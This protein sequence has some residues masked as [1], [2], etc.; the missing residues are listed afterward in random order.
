DDGVGG[1][2]HAM[3]VVVVEGMENHERV[4]VGVVPSLVRLGQANDCLD[5]GMD[6]IDAFPS[7]VTKAALSAVDRK[8][9]VLDL[10]RVAR[11]RSP[12]RKNRVIERS[13]E[14]LN[15]VTESETPFRPRPA[16]DLHANDVL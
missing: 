8:L 7:C 3:F 2:Q 12:K 13:A 6:A 5:P 11:V 9:N 10:G 4:P 16:L 14:V 15:T 1:V